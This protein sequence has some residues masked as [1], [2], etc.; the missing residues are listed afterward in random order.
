MAKVAD[1]FFFAVPG[2]SCVLDKPSFFFIPPWWQYLEGRRDTLDQCAPY[3]VFPGDIW[4]VGLAILDMLLRIAGFVA[5][6]M[7]IIAGVRYMTAGGDPQKAA[8]AR[9]TILNA[10]IGL[11]IALS[12]TAFVAF[13]GNRLV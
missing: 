11:L 6:V 13:I 10:L 4:T 9:G 5:V 3:F 7:L 2:A 8:S 1:L 12:A